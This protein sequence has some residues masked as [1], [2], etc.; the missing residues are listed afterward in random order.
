MKIVILSCLALFTIL[1]QSS[2][3]KPVVMPVFVDRYEVSS[4]SYG[5]ELRSGWNV[6]SL[7]DRIPGKHL[8]S[9]G[10]DQP[11]VWGLLTVAQLCDDECDGSKV[12]T[13]V[14]DQYRELDPVYTSSQQNDLYTQFVQS[15]SRAFAGKI[16]RID[17]KYLDESQKSKIRKARRLQ[18]KEYQ[19]L[20]LGPDSDT[21]DAAA[22]AAKPG[23][24]GE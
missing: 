23:A 14:C 13:I 8:I 1:L 9:M 5:V 16:A 21:E 19:K 2:D 24:G 22:V 15:A 18:E 10:K 12:K 3:Q 7:T 11:R 20:D 4:P 17:K 6:P